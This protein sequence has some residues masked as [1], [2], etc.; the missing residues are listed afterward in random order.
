VTAVLEDLE[1]VACGERR[2]ADPAV[3]RRE[4]L[5]LC[6]R[7]RLRSEAERQERLGSRGGETTS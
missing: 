4:L 1:C 5:A 3:C 7:T 2:C 6:E